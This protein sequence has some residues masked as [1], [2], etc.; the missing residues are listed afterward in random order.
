M[1]AISVRLNAAK[2]LDA[3][4]AWNVDGAQHNARVS[5]PVG[6]ACN[7][8]PD[9]LGLLEGDLVE[10]ARSAPDGVRAARLAQAHDRAAIPEE[11]QHL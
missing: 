3:L 2:K 6:H 8:R 10:D 9:E 7:P 5:K 11:G 4:R 1:L